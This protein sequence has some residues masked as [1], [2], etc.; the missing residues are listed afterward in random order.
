MKFLIKNKKS[1]EYLF[2]LFE[3]DLAVFAL[4][5]GVEKLIY[6]PLVELAVYS[7]YHVFKF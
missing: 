1:S 2:E 6:Q 4:V 5:E 7:L 3:V